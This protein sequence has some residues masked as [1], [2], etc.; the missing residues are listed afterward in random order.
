MIYGKVYV[1]IVYIMGGVILKRLL[2]LLTTLIMILSASIVFAEEDP[3]AVIREWEEKYGD[4]RLWDYL[5]NAAFAEQESWRYAWNPSIRPMLP[6]QDAISAEEAE[7]LA[8][9]LIPQYDSEISAEK[10]ESLTCV[11]SSYHKPEDDTGTYWSKNG[12]WVIDFWDTQGKE[13]LSVCTICIDAHTG[14]PSALLLP[15]GTHYV[16]APDN[17]EMVT[18]AEG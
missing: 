14:I 9:Q 1:L 8:I 12:T 2:L 3:D 18:G 16:G 17:A 10:L 4:Q 6:D 15:S 13:H 11:V 7:K 5:I